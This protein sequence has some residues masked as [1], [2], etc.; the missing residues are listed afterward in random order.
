[1]PA[2]SV[3]V[4]GFVDFDYEIT[5][6]TVQHRDG[7]TF[8]APIGHRQEGGDYQESWQPQA[9]SADALAQSQAIAAKVTAALGWLGSIWRGVFYQG[10]RRL[11]F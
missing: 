2:G 9:M 6:L 11:F 10:R 7:T 5:L 4:E 3:I 1:M 8:C